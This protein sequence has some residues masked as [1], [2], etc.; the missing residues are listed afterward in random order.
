MIDLF[1]PP[2]PRLPTP[3]VV[4]VCRD[5]ERRH[6]T[7]AEYWRRYHAENRKR[8]L[9]QMRARYRRSLA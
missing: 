7:R 9:K 6:E 3:S 4:H 1:Y 2:T 8:R 5:D